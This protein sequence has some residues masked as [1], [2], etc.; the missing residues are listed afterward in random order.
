MRNI[1][2]VPTDFT[3]AG[4]KA[5]EYGISLA[6]KDEA[7]ICLLHVVESVDDLAV[8]EIK[9]HLTIKNHEKQYPYIKP[10]IRVG[11]IFNDISD[12]SEEIGASLVV[13]GTHGIQGLQKLT[14]SHAMKVVTNSNVPFI[15]VQKDNDLGGIKNILFPVDH[16][17]MT[18]VKMHKALQL[19]KTTNARIHMVAK[20]SND[21]F[22]K[23]GV[24][25][26]L[27]SLKN[28]F[29]M[30]N[31]SYSVKF[32]DNDQVDD[33]LTYCETSN[34][35]L[36]CVVNN[37]AKKITS[38]FNSNNL[39]QKLITNTMNVPVMLVNLSK[40][41]LEKNASFGVPGMN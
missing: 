17:Q 1:I 28:F 26:N 13:M 35:D 20:K 22:I 38:L 7:N 6:K 3:N 9:L 37:Q 34:I 14:G 23:R 15:I 39:E 25:N 24:T 11:N 30:N 32:I 19:A 16:E 40:K 36:I 10:L 27:T 18:K 29:Q 31:T 4:D 33:L 41:F 12:V 8:A 5:L 2:L 21:A